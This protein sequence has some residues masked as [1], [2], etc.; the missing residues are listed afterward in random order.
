M[1]RLS[2]SEAQNMLAYSTYVI[3]HPPEHRSYG[4]CAVGVKPKQIMQQLLE[5][6]R[7][8]TLDDRV[9]QQVIG[10][11]KRFFSS[12]TPLGRKNTYAD[13]LQWFKQIEVRHTHTMYSALPPCIWLAPLST[14]VSTHVSTL[15]TTSALSALSTTSTSPRRASERASCACVLCVQGRT[16]LW[17]ACSRA[18]A[19]SRRTLSRVRC[20]PRAQAGGPA[21]V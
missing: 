15:S 5:D 20:G 19:R 21:A 8:G 6:G 16:R 18:R 4:M 9:E 7:W 10:I 2:A 14:H 12:R 3:I 17:R 13:L 11:R 1:T